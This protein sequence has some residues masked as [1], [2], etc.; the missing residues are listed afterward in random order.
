MRCRPLKLFWFLLIV[1][2]WSASVS[3]AGAASISLNPAQDTFISEYVSFADPNGTSSEMVIGTQGANVGFPRNRGLIQFD[4]SSIPSGAIVHSVTVR[5]TVMR[6]PLSP[7]ASAFELHRLAQEWDGLES[8][9]AQR[10]APEKNWA[11]PGG[12]EGTDFSATAS[13]NV[14]VSGVGEYTFAS[15]PEL[16]ADVNAWLANPSTNHG[17]LVKTEDE[18]VG[19]TARRFASREGF[20]GAPVLEVQFAAPEPPRIHSAEIANGQFCLR[21]TARQSR[22]YVVERREKADTGRWTAITTLLPAVVTGEVS[23]CDPLG[24]GNNFY[25]VG[26]Q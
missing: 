26:E 1:F 24:P 22:S 8:T 10:L 21:F 3:A 17:W 2:L 9:W 12:E 25:R 7:V 4:L 15:T 23:V 6:T 19:F 16:I 5:L 20:S 18:S 11:V 13:G 14:R